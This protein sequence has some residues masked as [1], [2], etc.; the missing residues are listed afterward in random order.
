[1]VFEPDHSQQQFAIP[2]DRRGHMVCNRA[3]QDRAVD[4][5]G[6]FVAD[7]FCRDAG[8]RAPAVSQ[9]RIRRH[10]HRL[11]RSWHLV[12]RQIVARADLRH[13]RGWCLQR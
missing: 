13:H 2:A 5:R 3:S 7:V 1:M 11:Y 12:S 8:E 9:I 10:W 6:L 4:R